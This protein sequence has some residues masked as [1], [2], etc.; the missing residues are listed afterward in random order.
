M[1]KLETGLGFS[2]SDLTQDEFFSEFVKSPSY[3]E[4]LEERPMR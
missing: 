3:K 2:F 1:L 4:F